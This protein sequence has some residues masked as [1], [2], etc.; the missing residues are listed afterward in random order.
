MQCIEYVY[1]E[2]NRIVNQVSENNT[3]ELERFS[4][5]REKL[6]GVITDIL[7]TNKMKTVNMI[8]DFL[9]IEQAYINTA[10]PDFI[11]TGGAI[12]SATEAIV[13]QRVKEREKEIIAEHEQKKKLLIKKLT[14]PLI[15]QLE[16]KEMILIPTQTQNKKKNL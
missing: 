8:I 14:M 2:L 6:I 13:E 4:N 7:L 10:H 16:K 1:D 11:G 5:L 9:N 15:K 3:K 12:N